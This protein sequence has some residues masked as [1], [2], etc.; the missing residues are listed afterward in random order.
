[1]LMLLFI[2]TAQ[3]SWY[4]AT[5]R[6]RGSKRLC[7][8]DVKCATISKVNL[9]V[10]ENEDRHK[11]VAEPPPFDIVLPVSLQYDFGKDWA[12]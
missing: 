2:D 5:C 1:M 6:W 3:L 7:C 10:E 12:S 11:I 9:Q 8:S 4:A